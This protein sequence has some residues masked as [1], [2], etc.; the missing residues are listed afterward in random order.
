MRALIMALVVTLVAAAGY[1]SGSLV[2]AQGTLPISQEAATEIGKQLAQLYKQDRPFDPAAPDHLWFPTADGSMQFLHFDKPLP[3]ATRLLYVGYGVKGRWCAED[4]EA[5]EKAA[6]KGFTHFHRTA[7]ARTWDAGHGG[8][9]PGE[10]GYWL[11]HVAVAE[12]DMPW[13]HVTPGTDLKFMPTKAPGSRGKD[14]GLGFDWL[15]GDDPFIMRSDGKAWLFAPAG[16]VDGP[17]PTH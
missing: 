15:G 4:Q 10:A 16:L 1:L 8:S 6:G 12:F 9:T 14:N 7:K 2:A 17:L 13:G 5:A 3:Q 11:K